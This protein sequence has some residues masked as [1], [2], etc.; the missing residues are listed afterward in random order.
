MESVKLF[1]A[2]DFCSKPSTSLITVPDDLKDLILSCDLKVVNFEVPLKPNITL[3]SQQYERFWQN[4]DVPGFLKNLGFN[5]FS[6]ANNHAFDWGEQG[7][8]KTKA[9]LGEASFGAGT[10]D[11]AYLIKVCEINGIKIGFFAL[12][13][14][15]YTGVFD[16]WGERDET[17][18]D[19]DVPIS[20]T[21]ESTMTSWKQKR[22][23]IIYLF[24]L[25]ME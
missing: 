11:E 4:D 15:A 9:A 20:M 18:T 1:F 17:R 10:Y 22:M 25:M 5:L 2:G 8:K 14:A 7:F 19:L 3:P 23:W 21:L 12:S 16:L 24:S 6:I 13:Y